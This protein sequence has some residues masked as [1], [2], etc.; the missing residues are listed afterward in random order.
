[1]EANAQAAAA[2]SKALDAAQDA[3]AKAAT[4]AVAAAF[5]AAETEV[6]AKAQAAVELVAAEAAAELAAAQVEL[7][8]Q[9]ADAE[10]VAELEADAEAAAAEAVETE[11]KAAE[12]LA[13]E[14]E[15][16][17]LLGEGCCIKPS[18]KQ[19]KVVTRTRNNLERCQNSCDANPNCVAIQWAADQKRKNCKQHLQHPIATS[20]Q[21]EAKQCFLK[22]V[23]ADATHMRTRQRRAASLDERF[24]DAEHESNDES[25]M[26]MG[27]ATAGAI[28]AG[29]GLL[30]VAA[31]IV[32]AVVFKR[33]RHQGNNSAV[34]VAAAVADQRGRRPKVHMSPAPSVQVAHQSRLAVPG[35][36]LVLRNSHG[37]ESGL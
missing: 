8:G 18:N 6:K 24:T 2:A 26:N 1:V 5:A 19:S 28:G 9:E 34:P 11:P 25:M 7:A 30:M 14:A 29:V 12:L 3:A 22:T 36:R 4:A 17:A 33:S 32:G 21:C 20:D 23:F 10:A 27:P 13:L 31:V 35:S 37:V 16:F 15:P